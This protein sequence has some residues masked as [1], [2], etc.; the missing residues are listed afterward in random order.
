MCLYHFAAVWVYR[1]ENLHAYFEINQ[2]KKKCYK[3][4]P[5]GTPTTVSTLWSFLSATTQS[6]FNLFKVSNGNT[7][8]VWAIYLKLTRTTSSKSWLG[9]WNIILCNVHFQFWF[10]KFVFLKIE[11]IFWKILSFFSRYI[12]FIEVLNYW[13]NSFV[14][15]WYFYWINPQKHF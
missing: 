1:N 12:I 14:E 7:R 9:K 8:T 11:P 4:F 15:D 5:M 2:I 13:I 6:V 3:Q 10:V